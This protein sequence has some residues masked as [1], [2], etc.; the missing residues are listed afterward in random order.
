MP[1]SSAGNSITA[2]YGVVFEDIITTA[3]ISVSSIIEVLYGYKYGTYG[4]HGFNT[5]RIKADLYTSLSLPHRRYP[6][7]KTV[8]LPTSL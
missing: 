2:V 3:R 4:L 6:C 1:I 8:T 7:R 5:D